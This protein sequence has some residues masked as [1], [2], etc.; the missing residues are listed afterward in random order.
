MEEAKPETWRLFVA[1]E[2]PIEVKQRLAALQ[3]ELRQRLRKAAVRWTPVEQMHLTLRFLGAVEFNRLETL[4]HS[5]NAVAAAHAPVEVWAEGLG[6]FPAASSPRVIWAGLKEAKGDLAKLWTAMQPATNA[7]AEK[8]AESSFVPHLTLGRI[9]WISGR[10]T[11]ALADCLER[12]AGATFG[13]W[14]VAS[15]CLMRSELSP[16]GARHAC[17]AVFPLAI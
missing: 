5:L 11:A 17:C 4:K 15:F 8:S 6:V 12:F 16:H 2:A 9:K 1:L 7:W 10:E 14:S 3:Q 13:A